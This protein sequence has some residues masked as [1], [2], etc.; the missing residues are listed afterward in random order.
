[1]T[2]TGIILWLLVIGLVFFLMTRKAGGCCG[3]GGH[4][5]HEGH[6]RGSGETDESTDPVCGMKVA[7][8]DGALQSEYKGNTVYFCSEHCKG[9]FDHDPASFEGAL[10]KEHEAH[11]GCCG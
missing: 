1:M 7:P 3:S 10:S 4:G 2:I 5:S 11:S 6:S 9:E 8:T